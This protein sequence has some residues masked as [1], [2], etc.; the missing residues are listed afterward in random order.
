MQILIDDGM[1]IH[2]GTGIGKYSKYL[3]DNLR[4]CGLCEKVDV[5]TFVPKSTSQ[6]RARITYIKHINSKKYRDMSAQ[7]DIVH[8]FYAYWL[9]VFG[10][11]VLKQRAY[12]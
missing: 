4:K 3:Y 8:A 5:S 9:C 6:K 11:P 10:F 7:Y 1:Q 2:I 12:S